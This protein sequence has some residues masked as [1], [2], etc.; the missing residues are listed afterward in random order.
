MENSYFNIIYLKE[1]K[2]QENNEIIFFKVWNN[3]Y[4][5]HLIWKFVKLPPIEGGEFRIRLSYEQIHNVT[6]ISALGWEQLFREKLSRKEFLS[7]PLK[8]KSD[9]FYHTRSF[10]I[11]FFKEFI[12]NYRFQLISQRNLFQYIVRAININALEAF[13][14]EPSTLIIN[15]NNSNNN[16]NKWEFIR[17]KSQLGDWAIK[18][19]S[20]EILECL[21]RNGEKSL[22]LGDQLFN[23]L[24]NRST[25]EKGDIDD[26]SK[27]KSIMK[28]LNYLLDNHWIEFVDFGMII[29]LKINDLFSYKYG[30]DYFEF[31]DTIKQHLK[32]R[33]LQSKPSPLI[34]FLSTNIL[35]GSLTFNQVCHLLNIF[36]F[37][38]NQLGSITT[39]KETTTSTTTVATGTSKIHHI[40]KGIEFNNE[41]EGN[42]IISNCSNRDGCKLL[43]RE[44][45]N[46]VVNYF[47]EQDKSKHED[48]VDDYILF[49]DNGSDHERIKN[50]TSLYG[51][52]YK[53]GDIKLLK[54]LNS[55]G[56]IYQDPLTKYSNPLTKYNN[57]LFSKVSNDFSTQSKIN[58]IDYLLEIC[59]QNYEIKNNNNNNDDDQL[60]HY[61]GVL[62]TEV[63]LLND[64][65]LYSHLLNN[66]KF[67]PNLTNKLL[68]NVPHFLKY[69]DPFG[70]IEI[71]KL[72][73]SNN[74][75]DFNNEL[76][77]STILISF[78]KQNNIKNIDWLINY[79][80]NNNNFIYKRSSPI[81]IDKIQDIN[82]IFPISY[83]TKNGFSCTLKDIYKKALQTQSFECLKFLVENRNESIY[84]CSGDGGGGGDGQVNEGYKTFGKNW[85]KARVYL[86]YLNNENKFNISKRFIL[87]SISDDQLLNYYYQSKQYSKFYQYVSDQLKNACNNGNNNHELLL[88]QFNS[89]SEEFR[90]S[91]LDFI[92]GLLELLL[93]QFNNNNND[94]NIDNDSIRNSTIEKIIIFI[95]NELVKGSHFPAIK[96]IHKKYPQIFNI[97]RSSSSAG[98]GEDDGN[99]TPQT[100]WI[101]SALETGCLEVFNYLRYDLALEV[102]KDRSFEITLPTI[103][104][105]I[106]SLFFV[107]NIFPNIQYQKINKNNYQDENSEYYKIDW[108]Y[109]N[110]LINAQEEKEEE[111]EQEQENHKSY[112]DMTI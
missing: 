2:F 64:S 34:Q 21:Q 29:P 20:L 31:F 28:V 67:L 99:E 82:N 6:I 17:D 35:N 1:N 16:N 57:N 77:L 5:K 94:N 66:S 51:Y 69:G 8:L 60:E 32:F 13:L 9:F 74:Q 44:W 79:N 106:N 22:S 62:F 107:Y 42:S 46:V 87:P 68:K 73:F 47:S 12:R 25:F 37:L 75:I 85:F 71:I 43:V 3:R 27:K 86:E 53:F 23:N 45:L 61:Y 58:F 110:V 72:V 70:N 97:K 10:E 39:E 88:T 109:K 38:I 81:Y 84:D 80:N 98:I 40:Y 108:Y 91:S 19:G 104:K 52:A 36:N 101:Y 78:L 111:E 11:E 83:L 26:P 41:N 54:K 102:H 56:G 59:N 89:I 63:F 7:V 55:G 103:S 95:I 48:I 50:N 105:S 33:D 92:L 112:Q 96:S 30:Q 4:L 65:I 24:T 90:I 14:N 18:V 15:N 76:L 100:L 49:C 93:N